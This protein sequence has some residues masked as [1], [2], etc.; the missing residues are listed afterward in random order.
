MPVSM[1]GVSGRILSLQGKPPTAWVRDDDRAGR[2]RSVTRATVSYPLIHTLHKREKKEAKKRENDYYPC[3][4]V[5]NYSMSVVVN[6]WI[7]ENTRPL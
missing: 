2:G 6:F 1:T 5:V 3:T 7:D 4:G